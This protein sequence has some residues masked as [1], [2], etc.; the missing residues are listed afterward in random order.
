MMKAYDVMLNG[1][2]IDTVFFRQGM[3][4]REVWDQLVNHDHYDPEIQV[5][6]V[7]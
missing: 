5:E 1:A 4:E 6:E 2:R 7:K 3:S